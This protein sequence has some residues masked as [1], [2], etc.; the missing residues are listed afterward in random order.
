MV[1]W[2]LKKGGIFVTQA[3]SAFFAT[4]AFWSI[5]KTIKSVFW[6]SVA[7]HRYLPSFWDWGFV[8][9][10]KWKLNFIGY[11]QEEALQK[12]NIIAGQTHRS[13]SMKNN[14]EMSLWVHPDYN[15]WN[16]ICPNLWCTWFDEDYLWEN[17]KVEINTL[18]NPKIIK[19]YLEGYKKYNL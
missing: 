11:Q 15:L 4:K 17:K 16:I 9:A 1:Y 8:M 5:E 7:Y 13:A 18:T 12:N 3:T 19:Y 6:N 10:K 2:S 14:V